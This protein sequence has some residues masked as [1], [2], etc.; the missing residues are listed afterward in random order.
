VDHTLDSFE[1]VTT[2]PVNEA[3]ENLTRNRSDEM[4][5]VIFSQSVLKQFLE[6]ARIITTRA[7]FQTQ[8][9]L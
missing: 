1:S 4:V 9:I 5:V 7:Q 6:A 8:V 3:K 2:E